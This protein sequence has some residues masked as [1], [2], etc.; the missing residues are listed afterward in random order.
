MPKYQVTDNLTGKT[1][2]I[3]GPRPPT[4]DEVKNLI[5]ETVIRAPG[6]PS[7]RVGLG[8]ASIGER[9][10]ANALFTGN[11]N[12]RKAYLMQRGK[13]PDE[14][15]A[16]TSPRET[17][18]DVVES[19]GPAA[20]LLGQVG[21]EMFG[22]PGGVGGFAVGSGAGRGTVQAGIEGIAGATGM[23]VPGARERVAKEAT[24][25]AITSLGGK[26]L[27]KGIPKAISFINN[28]FPLVEKTEEYML[29]NITKMSRSM[30]DWVKGRWT[31]VY[32]AATEKLG[33]K[34][35]V[36]HDPGKVLD[37]K[38]RQE[39]I[40]FIKE[41][42]A[43]LGVD[44]TEAKQ[45]KNIR[46]DLSGLDRELVTD[47][48]PSY[49]DITRGEKA[50]MLRLTRNLAKP[51]KGGGLAKIMDRL[52]LMQ[53]KLTSSIA[54][55]D[56]KSMTEMQSFMGAVRKKIMERVKVANPTLKDTIDKYIDFMDTYD[57]FET[58]IGSKEGQI[59][60][61]FKTKLF[62]VKDTYGQDALNKMFSPH[63]GGATLIRLKDLS[64]ADFMRS[65]AA[66]ASGYKAYIPTAIGA[67]VGGTVGYLMG[68]KEGRLKGAAVG[69]GIGGGATLPYVTPAW[70]S[71]MYRLLEKG[72]PLYRGAEWL[73]GKTLLHGPKLLTTPLG[74]SINELSGQFGIDVT[75]ED[76]NKLRSS[77]IK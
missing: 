27:S 50:S 53:R 58:Y 8:E 20:K 12:A 5:K 61:Y 23:D 4:Q 11:E 10:M 22:A 76:I 18:A 59:A 70:A 38:V 39:V 69:A 28:K 74:E 7:E 42:K 45:I 13:S 40:P 66:M 73:T 55:G 33:P 77:K 72:R 24:I 54:P 62:D 16:F 15:G 48:F 32:N 43:N 37:M 67:G 60:N 35:L 75:D 30:Q 63:L 47:V 49:A 17:L 52:T 36:K 14:P 57:L 25:G 65:G 64:A 29:T 9:A 68:G 19:A 56:L 34:T 51:Q 46:P 1:Y 41:L 21:G 44:V 26:V 3:E 31:E 2:E 71:G 6:G